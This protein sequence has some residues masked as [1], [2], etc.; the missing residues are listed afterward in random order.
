M[1]RMF[2]IVVIVIALWIGLTIYTKG[3][4]GSYQGALETMGLLDATPPA[5]GRS[6]QEDADGAPR[7]PVQRIGDRVNAHMR[8]IE[9][10]TNRQ[11]GER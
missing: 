3:I 8:T 5:A 11:I 10:R 4:E 9:E 7:S 1:G 6:V 2:G